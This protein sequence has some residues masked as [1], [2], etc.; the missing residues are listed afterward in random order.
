MRHPPTWIRGTPQIRNI[1]SCC[2]LSFVGIPPFAQ[3]LVLPRFILT[4]YT[5]LRASLGEKW[6]VRDIHLKMFLAQINIEH[7]ETVNAALSVNVGL[8]AK[9]HDR[10]PFMVLPFQLAKNQLSSE[11]LCEERDQHIWNASSF[12]TESP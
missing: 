2:S 10:N 11:T 7:I 6:V 12:H 3:S 1:Y 9:P 4:L 8:S 5:S